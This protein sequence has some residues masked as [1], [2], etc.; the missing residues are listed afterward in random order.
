MGKR[1][2]AGNQTETVL[3]A[4]GHVRII[5][6]LRITRTEMA[7]YTNSIPRNLSS[8]VVASSKSKKV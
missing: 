5:R 4:R 8:P 7:S 3:D 1:K 6:C 2:E